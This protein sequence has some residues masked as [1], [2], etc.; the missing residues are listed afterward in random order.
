MFKTVKA[1]AAVTATMLRQL[2][3]IS[4]ASALNRRFTL[5]IS[6]IA[7]GLSVFLML[8]VERLRSDARA[9]FQ[10]SVSGTDLVVGP[11]SSP[12][13]LILY[14]VF[15][16][17]SA[18]HNMSYKSF[19]AIQA[20]PEVAFAIPIMLGDSHHDHPVVGTSADY[21]K[22]FQYGDKQALKFAAGRPFADTLDGL[23]EAVVGAQVAREHGYAVD[24]MLSLAHG[25]EAHGGAAHKD[26]P[27]RVVGILAATGTPADR[28]VHV[29]L[30]A[31]Q[32]LHADWVGGAPMPGLAI[33]AEQ[34]RKF[35]LKP[36]AITAALVGLK[37]RSNVFATQRA[38]NTF[39][40]EALTAV[41]PSLALEE[42]WGLLSV[43]ETALL[44]I[45]ALVFLVSLL[46]MVAILLASL[47]ER[48]RELA[49]FRSVGAS[50]RD[51]F[52]LL[53]FEALIIVLLGGLLGVALLYLATAWLG[54]LAA[55]HFGLTLRLRSLSGQ[56]W[57]ML[58]GVW[59]AG[60]FASGLPAWRAYRFSLADGLSP[61]I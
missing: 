18:S 48:R 49:I 29:S 41:L 2:L 50:P 19:E 46:G 38:I 7:L 23:F 26:R 11:R 27:F 60:V 28:S 4:W 15:R 21:F 10:Q 13:Q 24:A 55:E 37:M 1:M 61:R 34:L 32:A 47:N 59:L 33:P 53:S 52:A 31:I 57:A 12:M 3:R 8:G 44:A 17:G 35:D 39:A 54:P 22:H 25:H 6:V 56:E 5:G 30:S 20:R 58:G 36:K 45:S 43:V 51:L 9:S 14:S 16:L 40:D 42:L